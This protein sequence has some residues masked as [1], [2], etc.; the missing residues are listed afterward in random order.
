M[1]LVWGY[2]ESVPGTPARNPAYAPPATTCGPS[3]V[4][5][6]P[7][8]DNR[9]SSNRLLFLPYQS[10][11]EMEIANLLSIIVL[12]PEFRSVL[13][14][15]A[16]NTLDNLCF[17]SPVSDTIHA[18]QARIKH[19]ELPL[20]RK[21]WKELQGVLRVLLFTTWISPTPDVLCH[22]LLQLGHVYV[23]TK[24]CHEL[25]SLPSTSE[26]PRE[27]DRSARRLSVWLDIPA[28][29]EYAKTKL[30]RWA[31]GLPSSADLTSLGDHYLAQLMPTHIHAYQGFPASIYK[32]CNNN[33]RVEGS[34]GSV[35]EVQSIL[36]GRHFA[37]K[38]FR[39]VF[40]EEDWQAHWDELVIL[41]ACNHPNLLHIV[42]AFKTGDTELHF[43]TEPWAPYTLFSFLYSFDQEREKRCSWFEPNRA[44]STIVIFRLMY[45]LADGLQFLHKMSIKHKDIK[46]SNILL[47]RENSVEIQPILADVGK[48][49]VSREGATTRYTDSSYMFLAPEQVAGEKSPLQAD[50]WQLG[51]C[52][53]LLLALVCGGRNATHSLRHSI[54]DPPEETHCCFGIDRD[55]FL[56]KLDDI[57]GGAQDLSEVL[58]IVKSMLAKEPENRSDI[59]AIRAK[60]R[61][62]VEGGDE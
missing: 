37:L 5:K 62:L 26:T 53:A 24:L 44:Q 42:D 55:I 52:F 22:L 20:I 43:V 9:I 47:Y 60:L 45:G 34:Y 29:S 25:L 35:T 41:Q 58:A 56:A 8:R 10:I 40:F 38:T 1:G 32:I 33:N 27:C 13:R 6:R 2:S 36:T 51:C 4:Q 57:C 48:S 59:H 11:Y 16:N 46:P 28:G 61:A 19:L 23:R 54:F 39:D 31:G 15:L 14:L 49:K 12:N 50:I 17:Q 7:S 30:Y 21:Q 18:S 3:L